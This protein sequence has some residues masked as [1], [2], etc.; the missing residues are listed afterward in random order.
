MIDPSQF[1]LVMDTAE[2]E[3]GL[4][5]LMCIKGGVDPNSADYDRRSVMHVAASTG[6]LR[7]VQG[8]LQV[9]AN[10]NVQDR[11]VFHFAILGYVS[12]CPERCSLGPRAVRRPNVAN[13][14]T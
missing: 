14:H 7:V 1:V 8:L 9:G 5:S 2:K 12:A 6:R 13:P 4:L 11:C 10:V 3:W